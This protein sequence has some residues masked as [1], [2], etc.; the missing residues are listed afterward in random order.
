MLLVAGL[1]KIEVYENCSHSQHLDAKFLQEF[2]PLV[3]LPLCSGHGPVTA[4]GKDEGPDTERYAY[5]MN[6]K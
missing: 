4:A 3:R 5:S 1:G 6:S 2:A